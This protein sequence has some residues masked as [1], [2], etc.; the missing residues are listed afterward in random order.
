MAT[1]CTLCS[2]PSAA[3]GS[4]SADRSS[5]TSTLTQTF[6]FQRARPQRRWVFVEAH[7]FSD[8]RG[9]QADGYITGTGSMQLPLDRVA[10]PLGHAAPRHTRPS[11]APASSPR[12]RS[13]RHQSSERRWILPTLFCPWSLHSEWAG[14]HP[15]APLRQR[16][17]SQS[18]LTTCAACIHRHISD[19]VW[20]RSPWCT[21]IERGCY[22]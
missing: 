17:Q 1:C 14:P 22:S 21:Q 10:E 11:T 3:E 5:S 9:E 6:F 15:P 2:A 12:H 20:V 7:T 18:S 19:I 4:A 16:A 8:G 13:L